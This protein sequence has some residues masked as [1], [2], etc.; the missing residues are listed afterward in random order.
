MGS[1]GQTH[2]SGGEE[3]GNKGGKVILTEE[4]VENISRSSGIETHKIRAECQ[5]F[6]KDHPRG[7]MNRRDFRKFLKIALPKIDVKKME[8][9]LFRMYDTNM[10]GV[11]SMQEFLIVYHIFS[12]G[13]P[14]ENL[15]KI[16]RIFDVDNNGVISKSELKKL[17]TDMSGIMKRSNNPGLDGTED[18]ITDNT[19]LEMDRDRDGSVT[20]D[21][22]ISS[23]NHKKFSKL[24]AMQVIDLFT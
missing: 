7:N 1:R 21:E 11:I 22:F 3:M 4:I 2:C 19:W 16:F 24:L 8:E 18:D 5:N 15:S 9:N 13:T 6:L 20:R 17:V 10:D 23:V 14:E 12:E